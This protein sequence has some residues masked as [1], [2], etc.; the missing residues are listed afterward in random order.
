M[1]Y[2]G[3]VAMVC[4]FGVVGWLLGPEN[5]PKHHQDG[6]FVFAAKV[7]GY[8]SAALYL[9]ARIPQVKKKCLL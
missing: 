8:I 2:A 9:F 1:Q 5:K 4:L 7:L 6:D 3:A